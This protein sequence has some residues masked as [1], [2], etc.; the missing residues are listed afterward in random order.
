MSL[1]TQTPPLLLTKRLTSFLSAHTTPQ[2]PTLLITSANGKLL[3]HASPHPVTL[4]RTHATVAASLFQIHTSSSPSLPSALPGGDAGDGE[5]S[6][7]VQAEA[8]VR[9]ATITVQ[10]TGGTVLIRRLKCGL[11][12]VCVGPSA[13]TASTGSTDDVVAALDPANLDNGELLSTTPSEADSHTTSSL[14]SQGAGVVVAM[15]KQASEL[16][17]WLDDKLGSLAVPDDGVGAE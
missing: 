10:L 12:F 8:A 14:D 13:G 7:E 3:A 15:R 9:P 2:T 1:Q 17:R 4:L 11:L 16:A 5:E 6:G